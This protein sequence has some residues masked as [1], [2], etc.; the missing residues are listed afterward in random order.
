MNTLNMFLVLL[1]A[2]EIILKRGLPK[3]GRTNG[4]M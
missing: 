4:K 3:E 2:L 1:G